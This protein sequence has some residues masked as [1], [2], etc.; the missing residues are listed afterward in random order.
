[1]KRHELLKH[2]RRH[3]CQFLHEGKRHSVYFNPINRKTSTVPR[4]VEIL[5]KLAFKICKDLGIPEP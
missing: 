2:I 5:N 4:Y 3:G 1:M